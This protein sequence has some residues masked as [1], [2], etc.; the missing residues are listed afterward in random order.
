MPSDCQGSVLS[1]ALSELNMSTHTNT[2]LF[3]SLESLRNFIFS[4]KPNNFRNRKYNQYT[5]KV[6]NNDFHLKQ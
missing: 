3:K 5:E 1:S 6:I 4:M 2:I